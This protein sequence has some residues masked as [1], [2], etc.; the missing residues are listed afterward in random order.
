MKKSHTYRTGKF[1]IRHSNALKRQPLPSITMHF[2]CKS[3]TN[4]F[5][6]RNTASAN[7]WSQIGA[8]RNFYLIF[9][10]IPDVIST[11]QILFRWFIDLLSIVFQLLDKPNCQI[12][13]LELLQCIP[14]ILQHA[15]KYTYLVSDLDQYLSN[16]VRFVNDGQLQNQINAQKQIFLI[17]HEFMRSVSEWMSHVSTDRLSTLQLIALFSFLTSHHFSW[18]SID[19]RPSS[20]LASKF[21]TDF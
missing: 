14:L 5:W 19:D 4:T 2:T 12:Q 7:C 11:V 20:N 16:I 9:F 3:F 1:A 15:A 21:W 10:I 6:M 18:Q 8:V 13:K 17:V